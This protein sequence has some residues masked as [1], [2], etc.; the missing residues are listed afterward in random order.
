MAVIRVLVVEDSMTVLDR[1]VETLAADPEIE[2]VGR[3]RDGKSAIELCQSLR[4]DLMTLDMILPV[5][6]GLA[7]T[8]YLMAYCPTPILIVS[9]S[10]NRGE[11][12]RTYDALAA[13]AVEVLE[14][15]SGT[16]PPGV[17]ERSFLSAIKVTS[18]IRVI[19]HVRG[20]RMPEP[21]EPPYTAGADGHGGDARYRLVAI[22]AST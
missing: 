3:A 21:S 15:P 17:W 11:L 8:E 14:K 19:T 7:V 16:E 18:R 9:S 13:G 5:L 22:G 2:V 10:T 4:P 6:S 20:R 12:Y 1:L